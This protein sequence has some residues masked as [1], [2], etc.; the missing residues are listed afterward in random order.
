MTHNY[1]RYCGGCGRDA[2]LEIY[3]PYWECRSQ[4]GDTKFIITKKGKKYIQYGNIQPYWKIN[5]QIG[6]SHIGGS[7]Q[8]DVPYWT[9][10]LAPI[11]DRKCQY[12]CFSYLVVL[13]VP[14]VCRWWPML[15]LLVAGFGVSSSVWRYRW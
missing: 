1:F 5:T 2:I 15:I 4:N 14:V 12:G 8:G 3:I 13:V 6:A 10:I 11:W 7:N 9:P